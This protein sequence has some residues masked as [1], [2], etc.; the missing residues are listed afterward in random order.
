MAK[1]V[2]VVW[3]DPYHPQEVY[4]GIM[5]KV[6]SAPQ[7]RLRTTRSV[8][9][10]LRGTAPDLAVCLSVGRAEGD[11]DLSPQEQSAVAALVAGGMG[12][13]FVHAGL[14][15]IAEDTPFFDLALGRFASHPKEQQRVVCR[16]MPGIDHPIL[17]RVTPFSAEDEAYFCK[18]D[19][20]R[21]QPIL[22][23]Q[24]AVGTEIAGWVQTFGEGRVCSLTPGHSPE[25]LEE[26]R[27][28]LGSAAAWCVKEN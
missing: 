8:R 12:M 16:A 23:A 2:L 15:C 21:A 25:M 6:F 19:L 9:D 18:V 17:R 7:W 14:A 11:A 24:S 10:L 26:M 28:L 20:T 5:D 1:Q 27:E 22:A 4:A 3:D 13:L